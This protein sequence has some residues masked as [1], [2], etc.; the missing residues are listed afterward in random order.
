MDSAKNTSSVTHCIPV[1][2]S[3]LV[4][5]HHYTLEDVQES[6]QQNI[7]RVAAGATAAN[8]LMQWCSAGAC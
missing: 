7:G 1:F 2:Q 3:F 4:R 5:G 8:E 6:R